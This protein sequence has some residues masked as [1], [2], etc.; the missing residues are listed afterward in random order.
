MKAAWAAAALAA[1]SV[2]SFSSLPW[3]IIAAPS[4][5]PE[6]MPSSASTEPVMV[7]SS[8]VIIQMKM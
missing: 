2:F 4:A 7:S 1:A 5:V 3:S 8:P 6:P